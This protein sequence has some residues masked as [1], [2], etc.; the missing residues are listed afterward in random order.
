MENI[1]KFVQAGLTP[2][3]AL[4]AM[5]PSLAQALAEEIASL[6]LTLAPRLIWPQRFDSVST[7]YAVD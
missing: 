7:P 1:K 6:A 2:I 5:P 4:D 3:G